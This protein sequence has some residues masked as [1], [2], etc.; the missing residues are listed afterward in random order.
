VLDGRG[1]LLFEKTD[2]P[3]GDAEIFVGKRGK[4]I[5]FVVLFIYL[6]L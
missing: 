1:V 3:A 6:V 4:N 5:V 2:P